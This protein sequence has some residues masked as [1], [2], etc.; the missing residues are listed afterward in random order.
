MLIAQISMV[1]GIFSRGGG[2][3]NFLRNRSIHMCLL[4]K[5]KEISIYVVMHNNRVNNSVVG[6]LA[7]NY[8]LFAFKFYIFFSENN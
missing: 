2:G 6:I 5:N 7:T 8:I 1:R 3:G 4:F